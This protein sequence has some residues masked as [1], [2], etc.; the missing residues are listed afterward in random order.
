M[1]YSVLISLSCGSINPSCISGCAFGDELGPDPSSAS[2]QAE[3]AA[4]RAG[5]ERRAGGGYA[6]GSADSR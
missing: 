6:W 4:L 1:S 2:S 3:P 5:V